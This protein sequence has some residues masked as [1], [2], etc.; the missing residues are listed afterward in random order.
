MGLYYQGIDVKLGSVWWIRVKLESAIREYAI[1][2]QWPAGF[3]VSGSIELS[4]GAELGYAMCT[5]YHWKRPFTADSAAI[6][7]RNS[8]TGG[9]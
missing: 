4:G 3:V 6:G 8:H 7:A 9:L 5:S 1:D 2:G